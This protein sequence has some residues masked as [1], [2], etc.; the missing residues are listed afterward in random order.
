MNPTFTEREQAV[1]K[2]LASGLSTREISS[3]LEIGERTVQTHRERM[4]E[5]II[6]CTGQT[7]ATAMDVIRHGLLQRYIGFGDIGCPVDL[8]KISNAEQALEQHK[9]ELDATFPL[10]LVHNEI[11]KNGC[12][13]AREKEI[14]ALIVKGFLNKEIADKLHLSIKTVESHRTSLCRQAKD[15]YNEPYANACVLIRYA[16]DLGL[17]DTSEIGCRN[18]GH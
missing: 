13:T 1:M 11:S 18:N 10:S 16:L 9:I 12:P 14:L 5:K 2:F 6:S 4:Y 7:Y 8:S 17:M 3:K 15:H